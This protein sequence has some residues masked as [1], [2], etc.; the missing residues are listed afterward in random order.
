MAGLVL[1]V[2]AREVA[3][4]EREGGAQPRL[5]V[6]DEA[7]DAGEV[8]LRERALRHLGAVDEVDLVA[9][10]VPCSTGSQAGST[11]SWYRGTT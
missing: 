10:T 9:G 1:D 2:V 6:L 4:R 8:R 3:D 11:G 7:R 5:D